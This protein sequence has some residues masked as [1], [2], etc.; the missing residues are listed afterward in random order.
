MEVSLYHLAALLNIYHLLSI[1]EFFAVVSNLLPGRSPKHRYVVMERCLNLCGFVLAGILGVSLCIV[2]L[3]LDRV[4]G[5]CTPSALTKGDTLWKIASIAAVYNVSGR[6]KAALFCYVQYALM[7]GL[8]TGTTV[9]QSNNT[10]Y[11][12][13]R[14]IYGVLLLHCILYTIVVTLSLHLTVFWLSVAAD[15]SQHEWGFGQMTAVSTAALA[16]GAMLVEYILDIGT[17]D[18]TV[19]RY[20]YWYKKCNPSFGSF[21]SDKQ[22]IQR[23]GRSLSGT[24]PRRD[25]WV[26][27]INRTVEREMKYQMDG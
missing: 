21:N 5:F 12:L 22:S 7:D 18:T 17:I 11:R 15:E 6:R 4:E 10:S 1:P 24:L 26:R 13:P 3:Q 9:F 16:V 25:D 20:R 23:F 27:K 2:T 14:W 19:P 8:L